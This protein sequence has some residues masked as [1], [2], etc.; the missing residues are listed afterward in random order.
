[1]EWAFDTGSCQDGDGGDSDGEEEED[2]LDTD[3]M[4]LPGVTFV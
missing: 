3:P 1:M 2:D 4:Q